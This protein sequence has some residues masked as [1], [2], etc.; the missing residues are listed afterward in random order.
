MPDK[1]YNIVGLGELLWDV[2]PQGKELGGAPANF[3]Y[4]TSLLGDH[5]IVASRVGSDALGRTAG[6]RLERIG[7]RS[8]YL[9][10]DTQH[11]TG[12]AKLYVDPAGQPTFEIAEGVAWDFFEWTPEWQKL[13][14]TADAVCFGS[15]AQRS[16]Q[17]RATIRLF[18]QEVS[19][20]T[21]R[22][23]DVNLRQHFFSA[24][25]LS[26]SLKLADIVK[27]NRE[28]LPNAVKLL[29]GT[30][31][32]EERSAGWI[33]DTYG[34]RLVCITRGAKGSLLVSPNEVNQH[35]GVRVVVAD[36][37]G[38]GD[39]FTAALTYHYL[40]HGSLATMNEA[41]NRMGAWV[42]TQTGATPPRD[43]YYLQQ[44]RSAVSGEE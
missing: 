5:G 19:R 40:R 2:F 17:S 24:E 12:T 32:D 6:R 33:R 36:T 44:I 16:P 31:I 20:G 41:A 8:K 4:M 39:A 23:F 15:L 22:I 29:G 25:I 3:A 28:E 37:V 14:S 27:F 35:G 43:D 7:L 9:Q 30:F 42:A 13:A 34:L 38:S 10:I 18:L 26:D 11:P 1:S 21:T